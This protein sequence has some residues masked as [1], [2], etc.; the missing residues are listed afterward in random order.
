MRSKLCALGAILGLLV[1]AT[2][3]AAEP[4]PEGDR[5]SLGRNTL[6]INPIRM[7]L[8]H[9]QIEYERI[10]ADRFSLFVAPIFFHHAHWYPF[11]PSHHMTANG[12]GA[13]FGFRYTFGHA[14]EG[15]YLGPYLSAYR[16]EIKRNGAP[17]LDGYVL[18]PGVQAGYTWVIARWFLLSAGAGLSYGIATARAAAP[19]EKAEELPHHG[20]WLNVRGNVGVVF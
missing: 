19:T 3:H 20:V 11:A 8:L 5:A 7:A 4:T 2:A 13:D 1:S 10:V 14:P 17:D 6:S 18:S 16:T 9:F 12:F 15:F